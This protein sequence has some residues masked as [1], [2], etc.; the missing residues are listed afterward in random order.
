M[1]PRAF[2]TRASTVRCAASSPST[3]SLL[4]TLRSSRP[5]AWLRTRK[6][7][8]RGGLGPRGTCHPPGS[9][10]RRPLCA[11][12]QPLRGA[13]ATPPP[14]A[15]TRRKGRAR[16]NQGT[17]SGAKDESTHSGKVPAWCCLWAASRSR[18]YP[19]FPAPPGPGQR[20]T[21]EERSH[22]D[23]VGNGASGAAG[24]GVKNCFG[25]AKEI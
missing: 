13:P 14:C 17:G 12:R 19:G 3:G 23:R 9:A 11:R 25:F 24:K 8:L 18:H 22:G 1:L 21:G 10:L 5:G 15:Q 6:T 7:G 20:G 2:P 16:D 4:P